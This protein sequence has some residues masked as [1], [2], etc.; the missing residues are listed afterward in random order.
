[1]S[2]AGSEGLSLD[3]APPLVIPA[4]FFVTTPVAVAV[5]GVVMLGSDSLF[6]TPM[7]PS[8]IALAHLGTLGFL[9]MA[10]FG[11]MYQ[12]LPVVAGSP[13]PLARAAHGVHLGLLAGVGL[14]VGGFLAGQPALLTAGGVLLAVAVSGFLLAIGLALAKAPNADVTVWGMRTAVISLAVVATMGLL[15]AGGHVGAG[16]PG[17]RGPWMQ[18][19]L[20]LGLLGWVGTLIG[21][22]SL[23]VVPMFYLTEAIA[24]SPAR[25]ALGMVVLGL[26]GTGAGLV[27]GAGPIGLGLAA[28]PAAVIVWGAHPVATLRAMHLRRRKRADGSLLFWQFG[29]A[30]ALLCG[31]V[32]V[33]A[34]TLSS[35]ALPLLFGWLA[36]WGWAGMI[37]HGML[38]RILPFLVWF[39]RLSRFVGIVPVPPMRRILPDAMIR[40]ALAAHVASVV[41][42]VVAIATGSVL[43]AQVTGASLLVVA[44][45]QTVAMITTLRV[46]APAEP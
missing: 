10:M 41:L 25:V 14:L 2:L 20:T 9:A 40:R 37:I 33:A 29:L 23:K 26:L 44:G 13:V 43:A 35:P 34:L 7:H 11:A 1:M 46:T 32:A 45:L 5:S 3:Q 17:P 16:F 15:M 6:V 4:A 42:G 8:T 31:P 19:H 27:A 39:H 24:P 22:V 28:A 21:A 30:I 38:Y 18:A 12:M 36:I